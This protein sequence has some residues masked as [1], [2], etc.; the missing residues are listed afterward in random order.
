MKE[1][2]IEELKKL[3]LDILKKIAD[4]CELNNLTYF[5]AYGTLLGAVRHKGFIPWD[6]DID[7]MMPRKDYNLFLE[8]FNGKVPNLVV[9]AP[10]LNLDYYAPYA[11]VFDDRTVLDEDVVSHKRCPIGIKIDIFPLDDMPSDIELY[12]ELRRRS[13]HDTMKLSTKTRKLSFYHGMERIKLAINKLRFS[14][15]SIKNIQ[16]RH[17]ELINDPKYSGNGDYIDVTVVTSRVSQAP[18]SMYFPASKLLFEGMELSVPNDYDGWLRLIYGDYMKLPP[19]EERI[20]KHCFNAY[21][22]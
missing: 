13:I 2:G 20:A 10:E 7:L 8:H 14:F 3:Q 19:E 5:L 17:L 1:I 9:V 4:Y 16:K 22:K 18:K 12:K 11:N 15:E 6:D 21:W